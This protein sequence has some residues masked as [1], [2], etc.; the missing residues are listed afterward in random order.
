MRVMCTAARCGDGSD[1]DAGREHEACDDGN[2]SD[3]DLCR[4]NCAL[5]RCAMRAA[6]G[7]Q[8]GADGYEPAMTV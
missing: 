3:L 8:P 5:A 7:H 1:D 6:H 4:N 2:E